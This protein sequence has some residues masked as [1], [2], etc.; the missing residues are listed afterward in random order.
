MPHLQGV[1]CPGLFLA[2]KRKIY[3]LKTLLCIPELVNIHIIFF[4]TILEM[5]EGMRIGKYIVLKKLGGGSFGDVFE[6][7]RECVS[8][9]LL[10]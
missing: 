1:G 6:V 9:L 4:K 7:R 8:L 2:I 5:V 3:K 10:V